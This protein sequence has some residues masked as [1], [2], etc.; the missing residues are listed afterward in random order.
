MLHF[1]FGFDG[2]VRRTNFFFG[3]LVTLLI[4]SLFGLHLLHSYH[5]F[6]LGGYGYGW[7][8]ID[9]VMPPGLW[10]LGVIIYVA[11]RWA[12]VA[13]AAKRWH[14]VGVTGW[15]ALLSFF[16]IADWLVFLLLCVLP[17]TRGPNPYGSDPRTVPAAA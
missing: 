7:D 10:S 9:G 11:C 4:S 8:A 5:L 14:D 16:H 6:W 13:L 12:V 15:L 3:T 1:F 2:R 17:P